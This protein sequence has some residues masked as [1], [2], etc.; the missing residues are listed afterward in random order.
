MPC[1]VLAC[2]EFVLFMPSVKVLF[3]VKLSVLFNFRTISRS[4]HEFIY[5]CNENHVIW[6]V[7]FTLMKYL[8]MNFDVRVIG[9]C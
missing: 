5:K 3:I 9:N 8:I 2:L 1:C 4:H 7:R 6:L